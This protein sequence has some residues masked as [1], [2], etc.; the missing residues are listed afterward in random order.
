MARNACDQQ[1]VIVYDLHRF[2]AAAARVEP[3]RAHLWLTGAHSRRGGRAGA[4]GGM[5]SCGG[6]ERKQ[7]RE[8]LT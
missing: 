5:R 8:L 1:P 2:V 3:W 4:S 6:C 7:Q